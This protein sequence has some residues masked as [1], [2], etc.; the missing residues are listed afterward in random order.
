[1]YNQHLLNDPNSVALQL[2]Y[3]ECSKL[4]IASYC[5][6]S[7]NELTYNRPFQLDLSSAKGKITANYQFVTHLSCL[8]TYFVLGCDA[9]INQNNKI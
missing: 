9:K 5:H 2:A 8:T 7:Y 1:M 6:S 3:Y 4:L